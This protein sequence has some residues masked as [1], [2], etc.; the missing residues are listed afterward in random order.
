M[1]DFSLQQNRLYVRSYYGSIKLALSKSID[2]IYSELYTSIVV[3]LHSLKSKS[4][5]PIEVLPFGALK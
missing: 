3:S 1:I 5:K 2:F 4:Q